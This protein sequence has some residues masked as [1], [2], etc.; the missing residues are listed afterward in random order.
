MPPHDTQSEFE[1]TITQTL[2]N[3]F[4]S[5]C[6]HA[7]YNG[8]LDDFAT[9]LKN[10]LVESD[11]TENELADA[12]FGDFNNIESLTITLTTDDIQHISTE[13]ERLE[14]RFYGD[15]KLLPEYTR[16]EFLSEFNTVALIN[17]GIQP[18]VSRDID[19][20]IF[21]EKPAIE[22]IDEDTVETIT[23]SASNALN[24][25]SPLMENSVID[26]VDQQT[27]VDTV[28]IGTVVRAL[29]T[30][31]ERFEPTITEFHDLQH[32][33]DQQQQKAGNQ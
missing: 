20:A 4:H 24:L 18:V 5:L 31:G 1:F 14:N 8:S 9:T 2:F 25:L 26:W 12:I 33:L 6:A 19:R 7:E 16:Q 10:A 13:L 17:A 29:G 11:T 22:D 23:D 15:N 30:G 21:T 3:R 32:V 27:D 28:T